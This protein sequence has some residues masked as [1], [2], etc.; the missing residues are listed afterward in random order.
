MRDAYGRGSFG[1]GCLMARR[2][3]EQ[4]RDLRRGLARRLGY[5]RQQFRRP[6]ASG[7]CPSWTRGC[8]RWSPTWPSAG[9]SIPRPSSGWAS[10]AGRPRINQNAGRDHWPRSWSVVV[11]G[12]GMKGGQVIGATDKDG[13]DVVDHPVGVM[14]LV[15]TMTKAMG[16]NVASSVHDSARPTDQD[17]RRRQADQGAGWLAPRETCSAAKCGRVSSATPRIASSRAASSLPRR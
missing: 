9:C 17:R 4:R 14:D 2:L 13:V 12:G 11:G 5:A 16:M 15:A 6:V 1:S 7:C 10:S 8:R 3:V